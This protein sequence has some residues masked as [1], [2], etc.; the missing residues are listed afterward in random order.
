[1]KRGWIKLGLTA[2]VTILTGA[3]HAENFSD[4]TVASY[5]T[6]SNTDSSGNYG[7][8]QIP[9]SAPTIAGGQLVA[10]IPTDSNQASPDNEVINYVRT[11]TAAAGSYYDGV[12]LGD[13]TSKAGVTATF[14]ITNSS[15]S[16]GAPIPAASVVGE[17]IDSNNY[18]TNPGI[19]IS[20]YSPDGTDSGGNPNIWWSNPAAVFIDSMNN[21]QNA[22]LTVDFNPAL[23]SNDIGQVG[24]SSP[25]VTALFDE[26]L[27][28]VSKMG[29]S[30][31]SGYFFSDGIGFDP[32]SSASFNLASINTFVTP[33]PKTTS[34]GLALLGSFRRVQH[35][36]TPP[37]PA[38]LRPRRLTP[39]T[40]NPTPSEPTSLG[41]FLCAKSCGLSLRSPLFNLTVN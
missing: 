39:V 16:N 24:N 29:V 30:F 20:F 14:N 2:V 36:Q 6:E 4:A 37:S 27:G 28:N 11:T 3:V 9:G 15:L 21:G 22:T 26:A 35:G 40:A 18:A 23:W 7:Y 25:A 19:R 32:A 13:L 41:V 1:M 8:N 38:Y 10:P 12:L 33:L 5:W 34:A 17:S 31:G